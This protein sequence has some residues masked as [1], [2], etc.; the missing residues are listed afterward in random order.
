[1]DS[2][3]P[4]RSTAGSIQLIPK[5]DLPEGTLATLTLSL[6]DGTVLPFTLASVLQDVDVQL[7]IDV[8]LEKK[9]SADSPQA[10]KNVIGALRVQIDA[11]TAN[12]DAAGIARLASLIAREDLA[13]PQVFERHD[14]HKLDK[15]SRLL[16]EA[17]QTYRLF[18][19]TYVVLTIENRDSSKPWVLERP[20]VALMGDNQTTQVKVE[21]FHS[22]T[23]TL[24]PDET[25]M[26]VIAFLTP[27]QGVNHRF[28]LSLFDRNGNRHVRL[29]NVSL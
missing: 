2:F 8:A 16:V 26:L 10:L 5:A 15:Q 1:V 13:K 19:H 22:D 21:A 24:K 23:T 11:C 9:A 25:Q 12:S 28:V 6:A 20:E 3:L 7:D 14:I 17:R 18:G 27:A 4:L 29:E